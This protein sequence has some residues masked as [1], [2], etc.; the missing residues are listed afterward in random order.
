[1]MLTGRIMSGQEAAA[2]GLAMACVPDVQ[3]NA[4]VLAL[5]KQVA[6]QSRASIAGYKMLVHGGSGLTLKAA[7]DYE[8]ANSPGRTAETVERLK[9][10]GQ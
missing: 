1:M 7:I 5:A 9:R 4:E 2:T 3:F 8:W 10:F 6:G